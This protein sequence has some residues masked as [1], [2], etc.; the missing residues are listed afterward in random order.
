MTCISCC[1]EA[2]AQLPPAAQ[3]DTW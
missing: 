2:V 3:Y 1:L